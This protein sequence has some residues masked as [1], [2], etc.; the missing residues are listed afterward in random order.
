MSAQVS[1]TEFKDESER[2]MTMDLPLYEE[3]TSQE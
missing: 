1:D 2:N 3:I